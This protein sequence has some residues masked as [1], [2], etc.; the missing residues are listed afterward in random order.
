MGLIPKETQNSINN[1]LRC[2]YSIDKSL[3]RIADALEKQN[4]RT[5]TVDG[6][7]V[8]LAT[9]RSGM[10]KQDGEPG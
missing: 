9:W 5:T 4:D 1:A 7:H 10:E 3:G 8:R 2:L 6:A